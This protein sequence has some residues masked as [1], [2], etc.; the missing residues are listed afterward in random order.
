MT[1][2]PVPHARDLL[3]DQKRTGTRN[4]HICSLRDFSRCCCCRCVSWS[5][6]GHAARLV[7]I[8]TK[9]HHFR[10]CCRQPTITPHPFPVNANLPAAECTRLL[11]RVALP[12]QIS[13]PVG[14]ARLADVRLIAKFA[15]MFPLVFNY[16]HICFS[17]TCCSCCCCCRCCCRGVHTATPSA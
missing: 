1:T 15:D 16:S 9:P 8:Q 11:F 3:L 12:H 6:C 4:T 2:R 13:L 7:A 10:Y 5:A 14:S 17:S